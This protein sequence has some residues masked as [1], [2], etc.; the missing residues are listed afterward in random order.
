MLVVFREPVIDRYLNQP[1]GK[2]GE[3]LTKKGKVVMRASKR[4]VGKKT[5]ALR[6]SIHMRHN[7]YSRGQ[8]VQIGSELSYALL[9]HDGTRP[10]AIVAKRGGRLVFV[11][12]GMIISTPSVMHPG[13]KPNRYLSDNLPLAIE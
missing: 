12:K 1:K 5:G 4:Q 7:R 2:V 3:Y 6:A 9:H 8:Y 13:T 11:K 10:H